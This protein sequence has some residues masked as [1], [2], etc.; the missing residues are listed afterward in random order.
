[1]CL[2]HLISYPI[3]SISPSVRRKNRKHGDEMWNSPRHNAVN[4][5]Q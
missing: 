1:M 3:L 4:P 5:P 2:R